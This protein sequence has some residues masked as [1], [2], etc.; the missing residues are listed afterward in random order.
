[1]IFIFKLHLQNLEQ[2]SV[3]LIFT[4]STPIYIVYISIDF[5]HFSFYVVLIMGYGL[6][7]SGLTNGGALGAW[8]TKF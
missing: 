7:N 5:L 6:P 3:D 2:I 1:M 8:E 4:L